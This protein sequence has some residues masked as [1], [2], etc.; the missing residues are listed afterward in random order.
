MV[1]YK[2]LYFRHIFAKLKPT[3]EQR[4]QA[5]DNYMAFFAL[6]LGLDSLSLA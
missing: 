4:I 6:V 3:L 1:L 2:E 5:F